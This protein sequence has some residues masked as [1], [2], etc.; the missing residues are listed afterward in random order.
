MNRVTLEAEESTVLEV[1]ESLLT[2]SVVVKFKNGI[3]L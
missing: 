3:E 2:E 1:N